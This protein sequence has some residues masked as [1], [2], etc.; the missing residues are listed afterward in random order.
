MMAVPA[1]DVAILQKR[2]AHKRGLQ[3]NPTIWR[4]TALSPCFRAPP[5]RKVFLHS[6]RMVS[7]VCDQCQ[8]TIKKPKL[9]AVGLCSLLKGVD[10]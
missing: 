7:F 10:G 4:P 9:E 2:G 6:G 1:A 8:D 3:K 5:I